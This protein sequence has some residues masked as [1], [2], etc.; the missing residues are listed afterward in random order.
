ME[1]KKDVTENIIRGAEEVLKLA[2]LFDVKEAILKSK[3]PSC[4]SGE[5]HRAFS[6]GFRPGDGVTAALLKQNGIRVFTEREFSGKPMD[7]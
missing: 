6:D 3:S 7:I 4:G 2:R 5:I 1:P